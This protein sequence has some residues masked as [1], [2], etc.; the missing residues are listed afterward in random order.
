MENYTISSDLL[1]AIVSYL[2]LKPAGE[3]RTI[4]N[5]LEETA[6]KQEKEFEQ[7]RA[8]EARLK[9]EAEVR[10]QIVKQTKREKK[11]NVATPAASQ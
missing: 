9:I 1:Q 5:K 3:T 11:N 7:K 6:I 4:L 2:N 8:Q 10:E